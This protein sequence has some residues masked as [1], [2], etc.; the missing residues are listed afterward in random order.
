MMCKICSKWGETEQIAHK[1]LTRPARSLEWLP[2]RNFSHSLSS[3]PSAPCPPTPL[4]L[5]IVIHFKLWFESSGMPLVVDLFF[6]GMAAS[7]VWTVK[8]LREPS[9]RAFPQRLVDWNLRSS[10]ASPC[11]DPDHQRSSSC[12]QQIRERE[13]GKMEIL[14]N[15]NERTPMRKREEKIKAVRVGK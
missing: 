14:A 7:G 10:G 15:V 2:L 13:G 8:P 3:S 4:R 12:Q 11:V 9:A 5:A 1:R 6:G